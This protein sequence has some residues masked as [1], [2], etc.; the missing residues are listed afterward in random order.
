MSKVPFRKIQHE[1]PATYRLQGS[2]EE[3]LNKLGSQ[4][5]DDWEDGERFKRVTGINHD[6]QITAASFGLGTT[7]PLYPATYQMFVRTDLQ[8]LYYYDGTAWVAL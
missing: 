5:Q 7:F 2:V 8:A 3:A 1:D 6:N 4:T